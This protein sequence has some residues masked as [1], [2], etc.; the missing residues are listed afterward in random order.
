ME[1]PDL[2]LLHAFTVFAA[3]GNLTH[4]ARALNVTQPALHGQL[5]RL[6]SSLGVTLYTRR[7]RALSLTADGE[8]VLRFA[9]DVTDRTARF[10]DELHGR[11]PRQPLVLCAGAGSYLHLLGAPLKAWLANPPAPLRL[12]THDRERT[13]E[14]VLGGAAHLGVAPLDGPV[15]ELATDTLAVVPLVLA[16]PASHA[17]AAKRTVRLRDLAGEALVLPTE[18][19]PHRV[20]VETALRA[21]RVTYSVAIEANGWDLALRFVELGV[22]VSIVSGFCAMPTGVV[23]RAVTDLPAKSYHLVRRRDRPRIH[24]LGALREMLLDGCARW[25]GG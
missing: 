16:M 10:V 2:A 1:P 25:R 13:I 6:A 9:R 17:L 7:G 20:A 4:A 8:R 3:H 23:A 12:L 22:G 19:R 21:A 11:A 24:A 18:G 5:A 14:A 15:S